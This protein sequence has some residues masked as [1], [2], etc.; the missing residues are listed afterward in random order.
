MDKL[1]RTNFAVVGLAA[2]AGLFACTVAAA[3]P[4]QSPLGSPADTNGKFSAN[5]SEIVR[6]ALP[7]VDAAALAK[8]MKDVRTAAA[9][10]KP[11][12][13]NDVGQLEK[14]FSIKPRALKGTIELTDAGDDSYSFNPV[15]RRIYL[16]HK[17]GETKP[18]AREEFR[19]QLAAIRAAHAALAEKIGLPKEQIYFTDVREVLAQASAHPRQGGAQ[20]PIQSEGA[21]TTMLRAVGGL[22]VDGSYFR[23]ISKD[24]DRLE[25]LDLRW[26]RLKLATNV[27]DSRLRA[28][29]DVAPS[30]IKRVTTNSKQLPV[31]V[32]M[33]VVL[34]PITTANEVTYVPA[35]RVGV[36]PQSLRV[37]DGFR[38][39]AGEVFHIDLVTGSAEFA[40]ADAK[41]AAQS[42]PVPG[43]P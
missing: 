38:T 43:Q 14:F 40:D 7:P 19:P 34:R 27:V 37:G 26:P 3:Q 20:G 35:V 22:L 42:T 36:Q 11:L 9:A 15:T 4:Q 10:E 17:H 5:Y 8:L 13:I 24:A 16:A 41:D 29:R 12:Q 23:A 1:V 18:V 33:A 25:L 32:R 30:V 28:P 39:D 6:A 31:S 2:W 21:V